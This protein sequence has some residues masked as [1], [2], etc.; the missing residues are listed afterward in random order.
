MGMS[1]FYGQADDAESIS[2]IHRAIDLGVNFLD[3]A[4]VYGRGHNEQLVSRA[5]GG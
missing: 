5:S 1:E 4:D 3:T 2:T